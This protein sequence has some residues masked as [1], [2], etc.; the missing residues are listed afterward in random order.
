MALAP[1]YNIPDSPET[2]SV[3]G[4]HNQDMHRQIVNAIAATRNIDLPLYPIDPVTTNDLAG[5]AE[6]HQ[7]LH[8][9]FTQVLGIVGSDFSSLDF[10]DP[11]QLSAWIFL[12]AAEHTQAADMLGLS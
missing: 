9:D 6:I 4:F 7:A 1:L 5:W 2:L 10:N 12:H 11:A 3:F 8:A